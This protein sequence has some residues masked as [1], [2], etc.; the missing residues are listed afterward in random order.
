V[1]EV[2]AVIICSCIPSFRHLVTK[3][4]GVKADTSVPV[5]NQYVRVEVDEK[6]QD[7]NESL[8]SIWVDDPHDC[9]SAV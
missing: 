3:I 6:P 1:G 4:P 7:S 2:S 5:R 9:D 8:K